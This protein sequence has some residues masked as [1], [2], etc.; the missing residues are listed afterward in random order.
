MSRTITSGVVTF[1]DTTD[2]RRLDVYIT[3][4]LPNTQIKNANTSAYTPDWTSTPLVL[5]ADAYLDSQEVNSKTKF[6]W[7]KQGVDGNEVEIAT[8]TKTII[9]NSNDL[10]SSQL[11]VYVCKALYKSSDADDGIE[12]IE[13]ITFS[14]TTTGKN[15]ADGTSVNIKGTATSVAA[16]PETD[17]YTI[18]Y[19]GS[20]VS[21]AQL[22]DAYMY[23]G[24]LYVC[25]DSRS[26][27]DYF[28]NVGRIQGPAGKDAKSITLT[29]SAQVFKI[30]KNNAYIPTAISVVATSVNTIVTEWAY[31][32][33]GGQTFLSTAPTG[34]SRIGNT[35]TITGS[36]LS[37]NS[38]VIKV[39]DGQYSDVLTV[40]KAFDGTDG[41]P[42]NPGDP[43]G[44]AFLTN[45][46]ISFTANANGQIPT[47]S[48]T[49]NVVAYIGT[50]KVTPKIGTITGL[51]SGMS[52]ID[53]VV[54]ANEQILTFTI[55]NNSTLGSVLSN[56]GMITIP[57]TYPV[58]TNLTLNWSK[59]NTGATGVGI[60]S[61]T[62]T[63]GVSDTS[64]TRP[65]SWQVA[66]PTVADGK[67]LW[68]RT[69]ID[70]TDP[71]KEDTVT[72]TYAK[73]G[74]VGA[75]GNPGSSVTVTS[76]QYQEGVSATTTPNGTWSNAVV[77]V[78]D[79]M[80]LWTKTTFS[81]GN[82]AYGVA[83]QGMDGAVGTPGV[84]AVT[85]QIYSSNG[86][87]L[88]I[89]TPIVTL[90]TFAYVGDI[91]ITAGATYQWY[92]YN[93]DRWDEILDGTNSYLTV[94][95]EDVVF[96]KSYMCKMTFNGV[97]YTSV[98]TIDDKNDENKVFTTKP[99]NY[100]AGDLWVVGVDYAP[101]GVAV[102]TLL[103][104]E[105][106]NVTYGD[107]DW[108]TATKYDKELNDLKDNIETYN[109]YFSFD[110]AEGLKIS[111]KDNNGTPSQFSTS[112]TNERLSFNYGNEAIAYINGTKMNIKEAE[113]E[114]PLT[115]TGKYSGSTMLQAPVINIGNFSIIVESNGSLSIVANI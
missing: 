68:T 67:Y 1:M 29:G 20:G 47:T 61:T 77:S 7:Y 92:V 69:V 9:I 108:V 64:S 84:D 113:I 12:D 50:T 90:Q 42:G 59:I 11:I 32:I 8:N 19:E 76:I 15:G 79:G 18:T 86:Y 26:G 106:T 96:S 36:A 101:A 34:V 102:G 72:Y 31:S 54:T 44:I 58:N 80:Y 100:A 56:N 73:Q 37:S 78:G 27:I 95:R 10:D 17:Y 94:G 83:K 45:E 4:N 112:L 57:I 93:N 51:P 111:A 114:S 87:A 81:D 103:R 115:V 21:T 6:S 52:V 16:I 25:T 14:Q 5:E 91:E 109:Q 39:S 74:S 28:I 35:V 2:N 13:K 22:N 88:S 62:V 97:E 107:V 71:S 98:A 43:A 75:P 53:P 110:S 60:A 40:Y 48:F 70:Y 38:L 55:A 30:N 99:S 89:N 85:F 23:N 41:N 104:A 66:I 65:T 33:N 49:T 105:H 82:V 24:D 46:N 3:S 63:Y